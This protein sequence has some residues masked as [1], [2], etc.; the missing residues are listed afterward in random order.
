MSGLWMIHDDSHIFPRESRIS[1][2]AAGEGA[3][4]AD[5]AWCV[6]TQG[7]DGLLGV[8]GIRLFIVMKWI[9]KP[10][11]LRETHQ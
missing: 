4:G 7:M 11:S 6:K 5:G 9:M 8:A 1:R 2:A 10:H 3:D